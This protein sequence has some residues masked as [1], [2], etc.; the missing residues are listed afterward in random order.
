MRNIEF[1]NAGAGSG[2]TYTL[3][4]KLAALIE[5]G[6]TTPSRVI[7]TTFTKLA[8]EEFRVKARAML[9]ARGLHERA[10]E[11]DSA[12][13]GTVHSMALGYIQRYWYLLG[14]GAGV[15][16][17]PEEDETRY[18][19]ATLFRV[20]TP[21]DVSVFSRYADA[22]PIRQGN[23]PYHV[24][25]EYWKAD[26]KQLVENAETFGIVDFDKSLS[27]SLALFDDIFQDEGE[28]E[29]KSLRRDVVLRMFRIAGE[30]RREFTRYK[31]EHNLISYN[32]MERLF[33]ELMTIPQ[34]REDISQGVDYVFVDEFQDS[35]PT[36]VRIFDTLSDIVGKGSFW[37]GDSKQAIYDF[38]G[39]DTRLTGAVTALI[40]S[41]AK[42]G[43]EGFSYSSLGKSYRSDPELVELVNR[44][45]VPV[46]SGDL[47]PDK[48][49]LQPNNVPVLP[50]TS[51]RIVH[52]NMVPGETPTG[53]PSYSQGFAL[54]TLAANIY[55]LVNGVFPVRQV[56]DKESGE[57]RDLRPSDIAVLCRYGDEVKDLAFRLQDFG[58]PV[59]TDVKRGTDS[60][61]VAFLCAALNYILGTTNL[62]DAEIAYMYDALG[63]EDIIEHPETVHDQEV[64]VRLDRLKEELAGKP[65]PY[66]VSSVIDSLDLENKASMW[67]DGLVRMNTLETVKAMAATYETQCLGRGEAATLAGFINMLSSDGVVIDRSIQT[68]GVNIM[69]YHKAKGLEW[70]VVVLSSLADDAFDSKKFFKRNYFGVNVRRLSE[71][72]PEN[73]Y[74]DF[75]LRYIPRIWSV[76][77]AKIPDNTVRRITARPD[78]AQIQKGIRSELSRL[79]YVGVTRARDV[80][81]TFSPKVDEMGWMK[82][83]GIES[84]GCTDLNGGWGSIWGAGNPQ[85]WVIKTDRDLIEGEDE[86]E[87]IS[88]L[89]LPGIHTERREKYLA[90]TSVHDMNGQAAY[91]CVFPVEGAPERI[92]IVGNANGRYDLLGTCLHNIFAVYKEEEIDLAWNYITVE[93]TVKRYGFEDVLT[94]SSTIIRAM[95][96]LYAFLRKTYGNPVR[97]YRELPFM[98]VREG[99]G[100]VVSGEMD[101]VWETDEGCVLVDYKNYP[102][103]DDVLDPDSQFFVGKYFSQM[104]C[105]R[106]AL[107]RTGKKVLCVL[108][109]YAVQG[110]L[111]K[112]QY[113]E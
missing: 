22:V 15:Q 100:Q 86:E 98:Y 41:R 28:G 45:F 72:T 30:W 10:A 92:T 35:N 103:Y 16:A 6:E 78:M 67:G 74:S 21:E 38:R 20:A 23:P 24:D 60:I 34:V 18:I 47:T 82:N 44:V 19:S 32:D 106:E 3:T 91:E 48:V 87:E 25:Y 95:E 62:L 57:L 11:M 110:R 9:L 79:L 81:I 4:S 109:Y 108:I 64:F 46:F 101:L 54:E 33:M 77:R 7:L 88:S 93:D 42:A 85:A 102:G 55:N 76:A 1:I 111:L 66:V 51:P 27:E 2:K 89:A 14:L 40:E 65:V 49:A 71:P 37:V 53:K 69:T 56:V 83:V 12:T 13:I 43:E 68:E 29:L 104:M 52:W 94:D 73:L 17:M 107:R 5:K 112:Q 84:V 99:S 63:V 70:N 59:S 36:Q 80:L 26:I 8:A 96:N 75:V 61:E 105:Y 113:V 39:C 97:V 58:I 90:P 31:K 50:D